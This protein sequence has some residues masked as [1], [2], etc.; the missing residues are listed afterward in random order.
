MFVMHSKGQSTEDSL[1]LT[2]T[3]PAPEKNELKYNLNESGTHYFKATFLNQTWL[4]Y[5]QSNPGTIVM[6]EPADQTFDIGL[7]R[8][9]IQLF[10]QITDPDISL[11]SVWTE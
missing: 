9:R 6:S 11:F 7:R 1:I 5:N 2:T 8:T 10:G 4:R 3:K